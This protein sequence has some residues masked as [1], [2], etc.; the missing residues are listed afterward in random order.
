M[1]DILNP[2]EICGRKF[3][4]QTPINSSRVLIGSAFWRIF[5]SNYLGK[6]HYLENTQK[7]LVFYYRIPYSN[8][9][10][11]KNAHPMAV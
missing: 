7:M 2:E 10:I 3:V 4:K 1:A 8:E 11:L 6:Q 9:N 5:S